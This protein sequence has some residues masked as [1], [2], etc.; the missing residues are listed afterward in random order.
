MDFKTITVSVGYPHGLPF[1]N[2]VAI[3]AEVTDDSKE[4]LIKLV[5]KTAEA[6]IRSLLENQ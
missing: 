2:G 3:V 1:K 5:T 4:A 6:C